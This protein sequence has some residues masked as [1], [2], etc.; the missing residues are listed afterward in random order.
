MIRTDVD[1]LV[2]GRG[3]DDVL[4]H[5]LALG[6]LSGDGVSDVAIGCVWS[7]GIANDR[8]SA[9]D[10]HVVFSR[11]ANACRARMSEIVGVRVSKVA[12]DRF[13]ITFDGRIPPEPDAASLHAG[14]TASLRA[15]AYD[16]QEVAGGCAV[17][18]D[19]IEVASDG[20][21]GTYWLVTATC[22]DGTGLYEGPLGSAVS[23]G[24]TTARPSATEL[25]L[26]AC[27]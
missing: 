9:G 10:A 17:I 27:R 19:A 3:I 21:P 18:G 7:D 6:D 20:S 2:T 5:A 1:L 15:G 25:G 26:P 12:A 23:P 11:L 4:G 22:R 14:T 8:P 16:H 13:R 24:G